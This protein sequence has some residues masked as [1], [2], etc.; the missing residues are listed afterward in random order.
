MRLLHRLRLYYLTIGHDIRIINFED[1]LVDDTEVELFPLQDRSAR[2][3]PNSEL[4][5]NNF[6][7]G[8]TGLGLETSFP[9][10]DFFDETADG[11]H[12]P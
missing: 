3:I 9:T 12:E 2:P 5:Q 11:I 10:E 7:I 8:V 4:T 6:L 1:Q